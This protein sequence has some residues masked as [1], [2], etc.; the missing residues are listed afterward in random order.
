MG[1]A[2][3]ERQKQNRQQ[4]LVELAHQAR[5]NK[6]K[7]LALRL[8]IGIPLA[9]AVLI[10]II[11]L[12]GDDNSSS[13]TTPTTSAAPAT[14]AVTTTTDPNATT[15]S[16]SS[17][18]TTT[19]PNAT[20]TTEAPFAYGTGGCPDPDGGSVKPRTFTAPP[21]LCIDP[22]KN[23]TATFTTSEGVIEVD[24]DTTRTPGTVNN[25]VVLSLFHYY[26]GSTIFRADPTLDIIQGGGKTNTDSPGYNLPDEGFGY[27]YSEGD[28]V[29]A[30]G[31]SADSG[32]G[33]WFFVAGPKASTLDAQGTYVTF[34][35]VTKGI[36]VVKAILALAGGTDGQTPTKEVKVE[37][38]EITVS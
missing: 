13:D 4:R 27:S 19:D 10:G 11:F 28:L 18:T 5:R 36:D 6:S 16:S 25:F 31:Q 24:L 26:D 3:R 15:T 29:M 21:K 2:K 37:K 12:V 30:R 17:T 32:G 34:G 22:A 14:S 23:Y 33:Q 8:G 1:T 7:R 35:K 9:L 38:V 20:T